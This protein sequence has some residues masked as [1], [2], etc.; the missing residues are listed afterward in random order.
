MSHSRRR[1]RMKS[2]TSLLTVTSLSRSAAGRPGPS[3][4][5]LFV[6][7]QEPRL[8]GTDLVDVDVVEARLL[9]LV[10]RGSVPVGVRSADHGLGDLFLAHGRRRLAK[11]PGEGELLAQVPGERCVG[12]PLVGR[13]DRLALALGEA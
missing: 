12:P 6:E 4:D 11:V 7:A 2:A 13:P 1:S 3:D 10:D 8:V 9:E 5:L